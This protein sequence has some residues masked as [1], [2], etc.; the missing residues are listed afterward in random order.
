M[1]LEGLEFPEVV[2]VVCTAFTVFGVVDVL[3][4]EFDFRSKN[5]HRRRSI[6]VNISNT[7]K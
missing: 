7:R 4:E 5:R 2:E 6:I 1:P 3:V